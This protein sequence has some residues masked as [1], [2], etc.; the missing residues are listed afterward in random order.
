MT[1]V[2]T[3]EFFPCTREGCECGEG[4][5]VVFGGYGEVTGRGATQGEAAAEAARYWAKQ[6]RRAQERRPGI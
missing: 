6:D 5:W 1:L 3:P 2:N 4:E